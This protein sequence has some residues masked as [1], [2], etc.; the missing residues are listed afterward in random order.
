MSA[1]TGTSAG[2]WLS[3]VALGGQPTRKSTKT[4]LEPGPVELSG[5][6]I[7]ATDRTSEG[8]RAT[9]LAVRP[10][11]RE[12]PSESATWT[13]RPVAPAIYDARDDVVSPDT[14]MVMTTSTT[15][16]TSSQIRSCTCRIQI[17][18]EEAF[19]LIDTGS[20]VTLVNPARVSFQPTRTVR[21]PVGIVLKS[22]SGHEIPITH[23][24]AAEFAFGQETRKHVAYVCPDIRQD[25]I[26][27]F[28]FIQK[29]NVR[30]DAS[31]KSIQVGNSGRI[32]LEGLTG[33]T[34][35]A[36]LYATPVE[37]QG[38]QIGPGG[39]GPRGQ[40]HQQQGSECS[41]GAEGAK[42]HGAHRLRRSRSVDRLQSSVSETQG[43]DGRTIGESRKHQGTAY[44]EGGSVPGSVEVY[45]GPASHEPEVTDRKEASDGSLRAEGDA[46][47]ERTIQE[48]A[49]QATSSSS[50]DSFERDANR[51]LFGTI[52]TR[53]N[54]R[55]RNEQVDE[56]S[57]DTKGTDNIK[58]EDEP[59][60]NEP[61]EDKAI[62][63][64]HASPEEKAQLLQLI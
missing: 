9:D 17:E 38:N 52:Q 42:H 53:M 32:P 44:L 41:G 20:M 28:D 35:L 62:N 34:D 39:P 6:G 16:S 40:Q 37:R 50:S 21:R 45:E 19:V 64:D 15:T 11:I 54:G 1:S 25:A 14:R 58:P 30:I 2:K 57:Q 22:A 12:Q 27:G 7:E 26:I 46:D 59:T 61:P 60:V 5:R 23:E 36:G 56:P 10:V 13:R 51:H 24:I 33:S 4:P 63:I 43:R 55:R 18:G 8:R 31:D 48:S 47:E 29:H 49:K 3:S